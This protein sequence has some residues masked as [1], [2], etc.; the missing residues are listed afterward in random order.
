MKQIK[1]QVGDLLQYEWKSS[2]THTQWEGD[3]T[4]YYVSNIKIYPACPYTEKKEVNECSISDLT[5]ISAM[6]HLRSL[7]GDYTNMIITGVRMDKLIVD[8]TLQIISQV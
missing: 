6:V 1:I 2:L 4:L 3:K 7:S 8:G 5:N